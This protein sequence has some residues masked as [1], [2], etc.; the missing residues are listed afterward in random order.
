MMSLK[1]VSAA[2]VPCKICQQ[3]TALFGVVDFNRC[4]EIP[5]GIKLPL[6]GTPVYYRRCGACGFLFT[7]AF[8]DW[9][10]AEFKTNIYNAGYLAVDPDYAQARPR[11]NAAAV[12]Q[13][14]GAQIAELR[15]LDYGGGNDVLCSEL[16][17]AGFPVATTYDPFVPEYARPPGAQ[18][19][20]RH[21]LRDAR[22][23]ARSAGRHRRHRGKFG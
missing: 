20:P 8:D 19:Q 17:A 2:P 5:G 21:L 16:R 1:P 13:L 11:S 23:H 14:F 4:C 3:P 7:D 18:I 9:S 10:D 15:V 6:T 22:T 12:Q